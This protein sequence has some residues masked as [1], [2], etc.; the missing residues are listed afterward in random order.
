VAGRKAGADLSQ[1][2]GADLADEFRTGIFGSNIKN[3]TKGKTRK[4]Y[5][6]MANCPKGQ[7]AKHAG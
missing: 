4:E 6:S 1:R 2:A 3:Q 7:D 5:S